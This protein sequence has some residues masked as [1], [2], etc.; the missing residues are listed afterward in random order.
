MIL[1]Q[2]RLQGEG[3]ERTSVLSDRWTRAATYTEE[4]MEYADN[5]EQL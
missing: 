4:I 3:K 5:S 2:L 1:P